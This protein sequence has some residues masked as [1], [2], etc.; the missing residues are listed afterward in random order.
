[1][2]ELHR[3]GR[4]RYQDYYEGKSIELFSRCAGKDIERFGCQLVNHPA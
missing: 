3:A 4:R 1:M 2:L